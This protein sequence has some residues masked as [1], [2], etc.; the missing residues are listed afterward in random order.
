MLQKCL[1]N[2]LPLIDTLDWVELRSAV[3][4]HVTTRAF[5]YHRRRQAEEMKR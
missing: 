2:S 1:L 3:C 5:K 4:M